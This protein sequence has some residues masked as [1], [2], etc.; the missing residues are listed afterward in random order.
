M[1]VSVVAVV[2]GG[3]GGGG[4]G[5]VGGCEHTSIL[6]STNESCHGKI[7]GYFLLRSLKIEKLG[8]PG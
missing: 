2:V 1:V 7:G 4:G 3:G 8:T 5:A 6:S